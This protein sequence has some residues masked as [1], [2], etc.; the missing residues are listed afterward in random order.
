MRLNLTKLVLIIFIFLNIELSASSYKWSAFVDK[1]HAVTNEA[2]HLTYI[3]EFEDK[4]ELYTIDFNPVG[5]Y[6]TYT[7]RLLTENQRVENGKR[8]N[9][10]EYIAYAKVSGEV[11]FAFDMRMKKTT[12]ESINY[13]TKSRDDDRE[14]EDFT[15]TILRQE[16]LY[17]DVESV[18]SSLVGNFVAK[19]KKDELQ[20][21]SFK[22]Y[23]LEIIIEGSGNFDAIQELKYEIDD[24]KIF[25]QKPKVQTTLTKSGESGLWSQKFAFV[26]EHNFTIPAQNIKY[27]NL[28]DKKEKFINIE[29]IEV[30]LKKVY[31]K[32]KLLDMQEDE[33]EVSYGFIYYIFT[34]ILGYMAAKLELKKRAKKNTVD[35]NFREKV[36]YA[37]SLDELMMV[38][39]LQNPVKYKTL[40]ESI[41]KGEVTSLKEVKKELAILPSIKYILTKMNLVERLRG[42][43]R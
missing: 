14:N 3:C 27:F 13:T 6:D 38:L 16:T 9:I 29:P 25:A 11:A 41:E 42:K 37:K 31:E 39:V 7:I 18:G 24:V 17:V 40:I 2:I 21:K 10:Y 20:S 8:V 28:L 22:P 30:E 36:L 19:I 5:D 4:G 35:K 15:S 26:S 33:V 34:F 23:H 1:S 43:K 32:E 12:Q